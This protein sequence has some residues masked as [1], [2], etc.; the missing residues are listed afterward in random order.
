MGDED[1]RGAA[2]LGYTLDDAQHAILRGGI[3]RG[4]W[5][6]ADEK[7]GVAGHGHGDEHALTL[8][9]GELMRK[10]GGDIGG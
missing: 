1:Q 3:Q 6:I 10:P 4:G 2:G 5:F 8:A 9:A 7:I